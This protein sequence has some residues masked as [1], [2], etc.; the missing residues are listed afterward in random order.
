MPDD[1]RVPPP[2]LDFKRG[3]NGEWSYSGT[4]A[5]PTSRDSVKK[6]HG[7]GALRKALRAFGR[8]FGAGRPPEARRKRGRQYN[9]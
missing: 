2:I 8:L 7:A 5:G 9:R 3:R 4:Y 1:T 6:Q